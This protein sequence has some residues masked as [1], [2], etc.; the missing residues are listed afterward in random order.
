[1]K[2]FTLNGQPREG[3]G[4]SAVKKVRK[5]ALV[6]AVL[7]R[8]E[9]A[10]HF[11]IEKLQADKLTASPDTHLIELEIAG[12]KYTCILKEYQIHPIHDYLL[13]M[14][15]VVIEEGQ[16]IEVDLPLKLVGTSEG[17]TVG[18]K[19]V[20]KQRKVRVRG[21]YTKLPSTIEVDVTALRLGK[22]L[23]VRE[24]SFADYAIAM[25]ADVPLAT[26]EIPRALRQ[27]QGPKTDTPAKK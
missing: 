27:D 7:S 20:Q 9:G 11:A 21:P 16:T 22:S 25:A 6:P 3:A 19:L 23:K 24:V 15:F 10:I 18:G 2:S 8:K 12:Q 17:Q 13:H 14:D 4:K 26:V 5:Q 1:M